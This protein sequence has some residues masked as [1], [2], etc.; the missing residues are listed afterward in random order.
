[1]VGMGADHKNFNSCRCWRC[2]IQDNFT[3]ICLMLIMLFALGL[4]VKLM[5]E[6]KIDDKYVTWFEGF[7]T[8]AFSTWTLALRTSTSDRHP[9]NHSTPPVAPPPPPPDPPAPE[10]KGE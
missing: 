8:G 5:H 9:D 2:F 10:V 4:T 3:S 6:D 7:A 1:M